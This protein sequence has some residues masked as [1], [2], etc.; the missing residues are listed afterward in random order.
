[1]PDLSWFDTVSDRI[2]LRLWH[3]RSKK[4]RGTQY[5]RERARFF[6]KR[7]V[8]NLS[9][10]PSEIAAVTNR[11]IEAIF[12]RVDH[13]IQGNEKRLL[14]FGC[15]P[16]RF[17]PALLSRTSGLVIGTDPVYSLLARAPVHARASYVQL[18]EESVPVASGSIDLVFVCLVLGG[19]ADDRLRF[20]AREIERVLKTDGV[21]ILIENT[22]N[23]RSSAHWAFRS[24]EAYQDL[25][26]R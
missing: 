1:V 20:T 24:V 21:L 12:P 25:F 2:L 5:W 26:L 19:I 9:H 22:T 13:F 11:Q 7:A 6:G 15:R 14:D 18:G 23:A 17:M 8:L 16:G 10:A 4:I 3:Y